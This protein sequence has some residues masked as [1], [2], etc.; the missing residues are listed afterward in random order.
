MKKINVK[1][2]I[3]AK[4]IDGGTGT[5]VL[6]LH[7]LKKI[8]P[9]NSLHIVFVVLEAPSYRK[10]SN[11]S[12]TFLRPPRYYSGSYWL[13]INNIVS[14]LSELFRFKRIVS[15][16]QPDLILGVDIHCNL[17]I[18]IIKLFFPIESKVVLTTH[19]NLYSNIEKQAK[20]ILK[21]FLKKLVGLFY[22]RADALVFVSKQLAENC[23]DKFHLKRNLVFTIYNGIPL[24]QTI[25]SCNKN[26][27]DNIIVNIS[28]LV[29]QKD[30]LTLF[31]AFAVLQKRL[32]GVRLWVLSDGDKRKEL[33]ACVKKL[34]IVKNVTFFGWVKD[35]YPLLKKS[36]IFVLSSKR[37][38]FAIALLEAMS[39][40]LPIIST[41]TPFGP[42]EIL[43]NGKY[44][45]LVQMKDPQAMAKAM[46]EL[47]TNEKKYRYYSQKSLER[48]KFF[49]LDKMLKAYKKVIL[50]LINK[51]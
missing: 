38:G 14:F 30:H 24:K 29:E 43:D 13:S 4:R 21:I 49:S 39:Q 18:S 10:I 48:V 9:P 36:S 1:I 42:S 3:F 16:I 17:I 47:L 50:N 19:I 35:I 37:E 34:N 26:K 5:Y 11:R 46:Y 44:G 33:E 2:I 7:K 27:R 28:R 8:F 51:Q 25:V 6:Q 20:S 32:P 23:I 41:D 12:F 15:K 22:N 31:R 45:V 40:G